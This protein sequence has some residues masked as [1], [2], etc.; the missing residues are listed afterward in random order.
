LHLNRLRHYIRANFEWL[1]QHRCRD[2]V[3]KQ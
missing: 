3:L 2:Q 1:H